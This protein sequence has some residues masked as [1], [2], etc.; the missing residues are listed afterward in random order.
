M[1]HLS[2]HPG[3]VTLKAVYEDARFFHLV[4]ELCSGGRL[5]DQMR[6]DVL[7]SEQKPTNLMKELMLVLKYCHDM[8]V[9][10]HDVKPDN[11]LLS[12]SGSIKL[13]DFGLAAR[14]ANVSTCEYPCRIGFICL[15]TIFGLCQISGFMSGWTHQPTNTTRNLCIGNHFDPFPYERINSKILAKSGH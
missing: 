5:L 2:S 9:I 13:A 8:G 12:A 1:Q 7:F 14:I 6:E 3:V 11:I 15:D 4:M 10:H